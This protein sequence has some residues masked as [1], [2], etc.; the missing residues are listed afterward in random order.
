MTI[1]TSRGSINRGDYIIE[2]WDSYSASSIC[3][4]A[5]RSR[6]PRTGRTLKQF[7]A[8]NGFC[9]RGG[10]TAPS[11][12]DRSYCQNHLNDMKVMAREMQY[13][14]KKSQWRKERGLCPYCGGVGEPAVPGVTSCQKHRE[15]FAR[16]HK[17]KYARR[18]ELG[19]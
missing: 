12:P 7:K 9:R 19:L 2:H 14:S 3:R 18:K 4:L 15:Y 5:P 1:T 13:A 16:H 10:C 11:A 8:A 6:W 17:D